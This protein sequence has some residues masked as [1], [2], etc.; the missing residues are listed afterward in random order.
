MHVNGQERVKKTKDSY[1]S[2]VVKSV[3]GELVVE[4]PLSVQ[5]Q[6]PV[7]VFVAGPTDQCVG[8]LTRWYNDE[9]ETT[10]NPRTICN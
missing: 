1:R 10:S 8:V 5:S 4:T 6:R 2:D 9:I 3:A 7:E